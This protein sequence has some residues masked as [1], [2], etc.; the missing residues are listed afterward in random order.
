[1]AETSNLDR[2]MKRTAFACVGV[3][4]GTGVHVATGVAVGSA[5]GSSVGHPVG[6]VA[7]GTAL[8]RK[9][10]VASCPRRGDTTTLKRCSPSLVTTSLVR[11]VP[12]ALVRVR[13]MRRHLPDWFT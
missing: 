6:P 9:E 12:W 1:M 2:K 3:A 7:R 10:A 11:K 8:T 4:V 5:V 13:S